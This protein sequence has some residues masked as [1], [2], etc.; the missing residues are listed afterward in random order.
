MRPTI[1]DVAR[2]I[3]AA[4]TWALSASAPRRPRAFEGQPI[5]TLDFHAEAVPWVLDEPEID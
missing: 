3:R 5:V 4:I 2:R 1:E